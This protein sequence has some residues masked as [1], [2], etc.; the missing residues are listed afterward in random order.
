[1]TLVDYCNSLLHGMLHRVMNSVTLCCSDCLN[2]S[3]R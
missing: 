2:P 3:T 1:M